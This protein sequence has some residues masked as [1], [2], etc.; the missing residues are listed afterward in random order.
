MSEQMAVCVTGALAAGTMVVL[1]ALYR[2]LARIGVVEA[3]FGMIIIASWGT[4]YALRPVSIILRGEFGREQGVLRFLRNV[5]PDALA[6][7]AVVAFTCTAVLA[8]GVALGAREPSG[9]TTRLRS[10]GP[11]LGGRAVR[12]MRL[13]LTA[14][15]I[16]TVAASTAAALRLGRFGGT[17][18]GEPGRQNVESGFVYVL[19]NLAGLCVLIALVSLTRATLR[20]G[21]TIAVLG[22]AYVT[23]LATHL[24]VLGGRA[25]II[26][27]SIALVMVL[28]HQLGRPGKAVLAV[29][30]IVATAGLSLYRAATRDVFA[31]STND[32]S[33]LQV[34]LSSLAD[35]LDL[36]TRYDVSAYDKLILMEDVRVPLAFGTTYAATLQIPFPGIAAG[37]EGGNRV[38]TRDFIPARYRRGVTFDGISMLGEARYNFGWLGSISVAALCGLAYG[39]LLRRSREGGRWILVAALA[40]GLFP[41]LIRADALNSIALGG[42]MI[43]FTLVIWT[44]VTRRWPHRFEPRGAV[45]PIPGGV[46]SRQPLSTMPR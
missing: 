13:P 37:L 11:R 34:A 22:G 20:R 27:V 33:G 2:Y 45:P 25:E 26:I 38:Y 6:T 46:S 9:N 43:V 19:V 24:L 7:A 18:S 44:A 28:Q 21:K 30:L 16:F 5:N 4:E 36:V 32:G 12:Q 14:L 40:A 3:F 10:A 31:D 1:V 35:P 41:S 29:G 15:V 8:V 39:W 17:F 23:F 42:T